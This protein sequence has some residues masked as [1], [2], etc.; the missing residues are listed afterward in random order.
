MHAAWHMYDCMML[1][2]CVIH[3]CVTHV[4]RQCGALVTPALYVLAGT[5]KPTDSV[6]STAPLEGQFHTPYL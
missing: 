3:M 5:M 1:A 4:C 2:V 6:L